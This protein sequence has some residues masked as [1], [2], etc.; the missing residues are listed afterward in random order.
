MNISA[1]GLSLI[2][3]FE[4]LRLNPY[5][6]D[7]G[8]PTIGYGCITYPSGRKVSMGDAPI[9][10]QDALNYLAWQVNERVSAINHMVQV[11]INQNQFDAL[12]SFAYN[13]GVGALQS[14]TLL[15]LLNAG[16]TSGAADQFLVWDKV[17]VD[18]QLVENDGLLHRRH[19]ERTLFLEP[20]V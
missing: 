1:N 19:I 10:E 8:I 4:G 7:A 9:T 5:L 16:N 18:G 3:S 12:A 14:S 15:R 2:E 6:D 13:E 20:V 17:R 11:P